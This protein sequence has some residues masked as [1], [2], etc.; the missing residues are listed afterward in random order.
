MV[1]HKNRGCLPPDPPPTEHGSKGIKTHTFKI[2]TVKL[3]SAICT[4]CIHVSDYRSFHV[5]MSIKDGGI[6]RVHCLL[7]LLGEIETTVALW[8]YDMQ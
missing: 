1:L 5:K 3:T 4:Y 2:S 6:K 8:L 7:I